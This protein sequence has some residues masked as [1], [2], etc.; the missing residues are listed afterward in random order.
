MATKKKRGPG[1][2]PKKKTTDKVQH[3]VQTGF[4][5]QVGAVF[6]I[7]IA[8]LIAIGLFGVGGVFPVGFA[9]VMKWLVGW[10]AFIM[11]I[12]FFWQAIQ[13]FRAEDNKL[14]NVVWFVTIVFLS[15]SAGLFQLLL[16]DPTT[17]GMMNEPLGGEGGGAIGWLIC[18]VLLQWLS[19]GVTALILAVLAIVLLLFAVSSSP[20]AVINGIRNLFGREGDEAKTNEKVIREAK[21]NEQIDKKQRE[22][23][24]NDG[25]D[26]IEQHNR[27]GDKTSD[28]KEPENKGFVMSNDPDWVLPSVDLLEKQA[29]PADPGNV[30]EKSEI[31]HEK[32]AEFDINAAMVG[33]N[34]GPRITQ[35]MLEA[36]S[37]TKLKRIAALDDELRS[38]LEADKIRIE[39][40]IP[41]KKEVG[42]EVPNRRTAD[43]RLY[44]LLNSPEWESTWKDQSTI[45]KNKLTFVVGRDTSNKA[46]VANL[47]DMPHLLIAG[48]TKSGKSVMVNSLLCS[49]LYRNSPSDL[50]LIMVDPKVVELN[51]YK[52]I[53]H[54]I[55]PIITDSSTNP[56]TT[57]SALK[58]TVNV[59]DQRYQELA[60]EG[61]TNIQEYN[62]KMLEKLNKSEKSEDN[63]DD[64]KPKKMPYIVIVIDEM[65]DLMMAAGKDVE[66]LIIRLAQ[67]GR[68]AGVHLILATQ[69]PRKE[70]VTGLIKA[71]IP[72]TIAFAV[73]NYTES[74]IVLGGN[75]AEKLLG[76]GDMLFQTSDKPKAVRI[77][78][79][80]VTN[81]EVRKITDA[82]RQRLPDYNPDIIAQPVNISSRGGV[83]F[84]GGDE[85]QQAKEVIIKYQ[86]ASTALLQKHL[87]VGY[88]KA[89]GYLDDLE[90]EGVVGPPGSG[91]GGGREVLMTSLEDIEE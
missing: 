23:V 10:A 7:V 87:K 38:A 73:K 84:G 72:A 77:Q 39:A 62:E 34:V 25:S 53:P 67:K 64:E 81:G 13:I 49:L 1:R 57:V 5:R 90:E 37:G 89:A 29:T 78:G 21:A 6:L 18:V 80:L 33:A 85:Y 50:Q 63:S 56:S 69:S 75:G 83:V 66:A 22:F 15:L 51:R 32:L 68:A 40:P 58:W 35:Y 43:V 8:I 14:S 19:V 31:I 60:E 4:W 52:D 11:P 30:N 55:T 91:K 9:G 2:P 70:V 86:R 76:T 47:S 44:G 24:I 61:V 48:Q 36:P 20:A 3:S 28:E 16:G 82:V 17:Q 74:V 26:I 59:M 79:A 27:K 54:L 46:V 71:N 88:A 45:E 42:I 65:A 41:G 12:L